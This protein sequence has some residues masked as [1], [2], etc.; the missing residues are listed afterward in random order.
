[1]R[2]LPAS[3]R[4]TILLN[5]ILVFLLGL[6]VARLPSTLAQMSGR[7]DGWDAVVDAQ[8][9]ITANFVDKPDPQKLSKGAIQGMLE[10]LDDPYAE[11]ISAEDAADF[12]KSMTGSFSGIGCQIEVKDG[13]LYVASPMEDSPAFNAGI[14][15]GDRISKVDGKSTQGKTADACIKMITGPEGTPVHIDVQ[16]NGQ[17][18][19]FDINRAKIVSKSVR[20]V[21]RLPDG[22][23]HWDHLLDP[24]NKIAY[25]R[26]SQFTPTAPAELAAALD[27]ATSAAGGTL[28]GLILDLR[29]NPGGLMDAAIEI[30][31]MFIDD[32]RIMST[33]GRNSPEV[34]YRAEKG[35]KKLEFPVALLV[36]GSSASASEIVSGSLSENLGPSKRAVVIG[37]RT[38]GK[39]LVQSV[40]NLPH[41]PQAIIK[42]TTQ[43]Y[44][45]PSGRL[46]Q[47]T[48]D[49]T[50]WGVD[51][52]PGFFMPLTEEESV[53]WLVKRR[54]WDILRKPG[55]ELP[56]GTEPIPAVADQHWN[57]PAWIESAAKDRQLAGAVKTMQAKLK[58]GD[59]VKLSDVEPQQ[60]AIAANEIK[61]LEKIRERMSKEFVHIEK[62][63]E[64]LDAVASLP[65]E[66][67]KDADFWP[68]SVDLTG[69][70]VEVKDKD[71]KVI[72]DLKI[73]GRDLE[74]WLA[75]ADLE[76]QKQET[77]TASAPTPPAT[78][79]Q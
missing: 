61:T 39:G 48:D 76:K 50:V 51:P 54:G 42:F 25:I 49:A 18:I 59:W 77:P 46:I 56:A 32:G 60:N 69:G 23:G 43:H 78:P 20:G 38:F 52:T 7:A 4:R 73:T 66:K 14:I 29:Y 1:M 45:L 16:R 55:T 75:F 40:T 35:D 72:A 44:Y 33:K 63:I 53:A 5:L 41:D 65:K 22:S 47:R 79:K 57:D 71:G 36:N 19:A 31:N 15:A 27:Q 28:N 12:E 67:A 30:V 2:S 8:R 26:M 68:D 6:F 74:R 13:W 21:R 62:K 10:S 17:D 24:E 58:T 37:T 64:T 9:M 34:V 11:Y 70:L 3:P